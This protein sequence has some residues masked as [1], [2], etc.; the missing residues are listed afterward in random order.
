MPYNRSILIETS[1]QSCLIYL[2][3]QKKS[4]SSLFFP[5]R[6][7]LLCLSFLNNL[8]RFPIT[9]PTVQLFYPYPKQTDSITYPSETYLSN[10]ITRPKQKCLSQPKYYYCCT[11]TSKTVL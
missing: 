4:V 1:K 2:H 10:L 7:Y 3:R 5:K 9:N 11:Y 8:A 6:K